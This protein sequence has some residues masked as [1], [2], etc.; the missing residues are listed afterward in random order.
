MGDLQS[1]HIPP[2]SYEL[3]RFARIIRKI[4]MNAYAEEEIIVNISVLSSEV[5]ECIDLIH[6]VL[7]SDDPDKMLGSPLYMVIEGALN[8][9]MDTDDEYREFLNFILEELEK[10]QKEIQD[11]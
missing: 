8:W 10:R 11:Q 7:Q 6:K 5:Q 1:F 3:K 4:G 2:P 9:S